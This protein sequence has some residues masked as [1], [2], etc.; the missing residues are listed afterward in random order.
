[1]KTPRSIALA[2]PTSVPLI[3]PRACVIAY[4]EGREVQALGFSEHPEVSVAGGRLL[5]DLDIRSSENQAMAIS[6]NF[7][8]LDGVCHDIACALEFPFEEW[9]EDHWVFLPACVYEGNRF[10]KDEGS[11]KSIPHQPEPDPFNWIRLSSAPHLTHGPGSSRLQVLTGDCSTP[12]VGVYSP[13]L[14]RGFLLITDQGTAHGDHALEVVESTDRR[15]ARILLKS[16]GVR[17]GGKYNY[18]GKLADRPM[19]LAHQE[20][21]SMGALVYHFHA[22]SPEDLYAFFVRV[23]KEWAPQRER[24]DLPFSSAFR[25]IEQKHQR[26]NWVESH[27][28]WSVGMRESPPQDFQTGW[29]GGPNTVWPLLVRGDAHSFHCAL[30]SW[31]FII[32]SAMPSGFVASRF[33]GSSW[34]DEGRPCYLR[35]S[36]DTLYFIMKT[37]LHLR[38]G[39]PHINPDPAWVRF[40]RNL[41]DALVRMWRE[42]GHLGHYA[43]PQTG[44]I[45]LGGSCAAALAPA[46]LALAARYFGNPEYREV[47]ESS[48]RRYR[49]HFLAHGFTNGGPGDIFQ[50]VDSESA[51]ALLESFVVLMEESGGQT[52]WIEAAER[53]AAYFA[54]WVTSYDFRFP[55]DST[56]GRLDMLTTGTVWAN[57]QNKHAAPGICTL[58]G[59]SLLKLWR[60]TGDA[61]WLDLIRDIAR[62]LTQYI[63]RSDRP[64]VDTRVG[65]RWKVMPAGWVNERVNL[66]DWEVRGEPWEEIG[67]GEIFGGSCWS[68]PAILNTIAEVPGIVLN[69]DTL[70]M[71]VLDHVF[72]QTVHVSPDTITLRITNPT[73][74]DAAPV[75]LAERT[76]ERRA[77]W[78]GVHPLVGLPALS[79]PPLATRDFSV[80]RIT[81]IRQQPD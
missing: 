44:A 22:K 21:F 51:A 70:E 32:Q 20:T 72:A 80:P 73:P 16:P 64:I 38:V 61:V 69:T 4:E 81:P 28:Y 39:P 1:M 77:R 43:D 18:T 30:R 53:A 7:K 31:D 9:G 63:S 29:V 50:N 27:G 36:A 55:P 48:A 6:A 42:A 2:E 23:R 33:D 67:V 5:A 41:T 12:C 66:S 3:H 19:T 52:E 74:F 26:D 56:F 62:C 40:A 8:V 14:R 10:P 15:S 17:D 47:A 13:G 58:S 65:K 54:T 35:Y 49:D 34:N 79:V 59:A 37:L 75:L 68:E 24:A 25:L 45:H 76:S 11:K 71:T 78:L 57:V 60:A 46:G